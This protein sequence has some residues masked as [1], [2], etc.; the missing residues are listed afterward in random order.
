MDKQ[1]K[2]SQLALVKLAKLENSANIVK[3]PQVYFAKI[4]KSPE[5]SDSITFK[6]LTKRIKVDDI[7]HSEKLFVYSIT[8]LSS[9]LKKDIQYISYKTMK[10]E[11][12]K[13]NK[14]ILSRK[15]AKVEFLK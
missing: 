2:V 6:I 9:I 14:K 15:K 13:L 12:N 11:E 7:P 3:F 4:I 1:Y 5:P 10:T 8:P